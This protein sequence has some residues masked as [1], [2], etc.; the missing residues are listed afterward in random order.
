MTDTTLNPLVE[1]VVCTL[2]ADRP[3]KWSEVLDGRT[4]ARTWLVGVTAF[5]FGG[6]INRAAVQAWIDGHVDRIRA[7]DAADAAG[8]KTWAHSRM[9]QLTSACGIPEDVAPATEDVVA[10]AVV[11][12][13]ASEFLVSMTDK[14]EGNHDDLDKPP[15][16]EFRIDTSDP[17]KLH[18]I[19]VTRTQLLPDGSLSIV[20]TPADPNDTEEWVTLDMKSPTVAPTIPASSIK[21]TVTLTKSELTKLLEQAFAEGVGCDERYEGGADNQ[22]ACVTDILED[23][24]FEGSTR[25]EDMTP[26][27]RKQVAGMTHAYISA[28]LAEAIAKL[29]AMD[30][31]PG[32]LFE[33][34]PTY[35]VVYFEHLAAFMFDVLKSD[36]V[37]TPA[38][39]AEQAAIAR[40]IDD[41][42]FQF[43]QGKRMSEEDVELYRKALMAYPKSEIDI[44][45]MPGEFKPIPGENPEIDY[46]QL[47]G[48]LYEII[49]SA[50]VCTYDDARPARPFHLDE[51]IAPFTD[52]GTRTE[53]EHIIAK[54]IDR[55]LGRFKDRVKLPDVDV[56]NYKAALAFANGLR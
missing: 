13:T 39:D 8:G 37:V 32:G 3:D 36:N 54:A 55:G 22:L 51:A 4:E 44:Y 14:A 53:A 10:M 47:G 40:A 15:R 29:D 6:E 21:P 52:N 23:V 1:R 17:E 25:L 20:T 2:V 48:W 11:E 19:D 12:G 24:L 34:P 46:D 41:A 27:Q 45:E 35:G 56:E 7:L 30:L 16:M 31:R 50:G 5:H 43:R 42:I 26:E 33:L 49:S 28:D 9:P 38:E 18:I